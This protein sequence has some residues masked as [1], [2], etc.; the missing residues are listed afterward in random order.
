[1]KFVAGGTGEILE[2]PTQTPFRPP[3]S[4]HGVLETRTQDHSGG[5]R[6]CNRLGRPFLKL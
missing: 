6:A 3:R 1:M 2:K 5:R 4:P